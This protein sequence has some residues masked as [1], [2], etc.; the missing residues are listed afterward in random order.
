MS[1]KNDENLDEEYMDKYGCT[2][3][4]LLD[5][6][7]NLHVDEFKTLLMI[8]NLYAGVTH[9]DNQIVFN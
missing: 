7:Q 1:D 4:Q 5:K 8:Y 9:I 6:Y 2:H 3:K